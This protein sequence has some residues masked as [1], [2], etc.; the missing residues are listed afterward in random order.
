M[1]TSFL[2][3]VS[4][5]AIIALIALGTLRQVQWQATQERERREQDR[6]EQLRR[7]LRYEHSEQEIERLKTELEQ[8]R[9]SRRRDVE[10]LTNL[11]DRLTAELAACRSGMRRH[12]IA[13]SVNQNQIGSGAD[14][15]QAA[16]GDDIEQDAP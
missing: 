13:L 16:A 9:E 3:L 5:L 10:R 12:G 1:D 8:E 15:G 7:D 14:V 4:I 11:V 6:I 2:T